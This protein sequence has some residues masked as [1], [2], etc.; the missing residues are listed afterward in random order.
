MSDK[1][2]FH[3]TKAAEEGYKSVAGV[4]EAGRGPLAG[5][6]VAAAVVVR[7]PSFR[8]KIADSKKLSEKKRQRA[9]VEI[10]EKCEVGIGEAG[11]KE[12]D[13]FNIHNATLL[14][15]KRAV[16]DLKTKPDYL[17]IDGR[18]NIP[19]AQERT[20]LVSGED[21]S[22]SIAAASIIAKVYR[23]S[24]MMKLDRLFPRY[25]F[26][27]HKGYGTK[28]HFRAI[29]KYG[30]SS[31]HRKT[32]SPCCNIDKIGYVHRSSVT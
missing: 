25:G 5:P 1:R 20:C 16:E 17:L 12:I 28:E 27:K 21:K 23:D 13:E 15:M 2:F 24:I 22:V 6:V 4:D 11:E 29:K 32:F 3:E 8:E 31:V 26:R 14:A 19:V 30:P 18:M 9:F 7:D 10:F